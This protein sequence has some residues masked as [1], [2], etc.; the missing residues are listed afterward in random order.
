[1]A[2][3]S[4]YTS[5]NFNSYVATIGEMD[6]LINSLEGVVD[7]S[8]W[9]ALDNDLIKE[10]LIIR[11]VDDFNSFCFLGTLNGSVLS[12][13]NM[14]FP[15]SGLSYNN[16]VSIGETDF[17]PFLLEYIS[18]RCIERLEYDENEIASKGSSTNVKKQKVGS[19]EQ[20]FFSPSEAQFTVV[21]LRKMP[22]FAYI[23]PYIVNSSSSMRFVQR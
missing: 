2:L 4:V 8:K 23:K 6:T 7:I 20:E 15:R 10:N 14:M 1:M 12:P 18:R 3:D 5:I 22:S 11:S 9:C 13:F 21:S 16:G 19:L 17:P